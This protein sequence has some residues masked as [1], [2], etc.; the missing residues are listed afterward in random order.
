MD[1]VHN[2]K[3]EV[4]EL[5]II[6]EYYK[7]IQP[8]VS[9]SDNEISYQESKPNNKIENLVYCFWQLKAQKLLNNDYNYR[10]VSDGCIDIFFNCKQPME[11]FVMGFCRRFVQFPIGK[12]FDYIGIRFL[13]SAFSY[14]FGVDARSLSN[15]SQEL[16][17]VLPNFSDWINSEIKPT[18][19]FENIKK[20]LN[21]KIIGFSKRQDVHYDQ[22]FLD[23]L[24]LILKKNGNLNT[25]KDLNTGLSPRQLRR[26][27][28]FYIGTT[29]KSFSNVVRFQY[30]LNAKPSKQSLRE[31]KLY[32]DVG[33][34]DQAHFVKS[35]KTYYGVTP[36]E[37]FH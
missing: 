9:D 6:R 20:I 17:K 36:S 3:K 25:E 16:I 29:A 10:V 5:K 22:R 8:T 31:N 30:I 35:F 7:P 13:P 32:F 26:I 4:N 24:S 2:A 33:F 12:E 27:F 1:V 15:Q 11:S 18:D 23:S 19:S 34:F 14:L 37:A 21:E 28:N